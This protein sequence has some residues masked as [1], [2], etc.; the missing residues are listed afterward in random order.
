MYS[1][2]VV[3]AKEVEAKS[4]QEAVE[5]YKSPDTVAYID[6]NTPGG[7]C[8]ERF[9]ELMAV[10]FPGRGAEEESMTSEIHARVTFVKNEEDVAI[11]PDGV[12]EK[13]A[14]ASCPG[15]WPDDYFMGR[16]VDDEDNMYL[17]LV[18]FEQK[19]PDDGDDDLLIQLAKQQLEQNKKAAAKN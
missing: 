13:M 19:L 5:K 16:Y 8:Q 14:W 6:L 12:I 11:I 3:T 15:D 18:R 1:F 17:I 10:S 7:V 4:L 9:S 2:L